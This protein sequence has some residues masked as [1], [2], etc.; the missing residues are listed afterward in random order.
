MAWWRIVGG[1][2]WRKAAV[3]CAEG[4]RMA[5]TVGELSAAGKSIGRTCKTRL[6]A[7]ICL[8][9]GTINVPSSH[10]VEV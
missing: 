2:E 7:Q 3:R 8:P 5:A 10:A 4:S 9:V 6:H 1:L